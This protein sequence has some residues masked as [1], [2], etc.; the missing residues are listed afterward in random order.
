MQTTTRRAVL[1]GA[2]A[3]AAGLVLE[4]APAS[5]A[6]PVILPAADPIAHLLRRATFGPTPAALAEATRL[7]AAGW[8]DRQLNPATIADGDLD[9]L[10]TR[11][12]L[13]NA[14][15]PTV[16]AKLPKYS[17]DAFGDLGRAAVARAI[18]SN[19]QL[20]E[21]VA[22]FWAN[23]LHI[24]SPSSGVW[25][26]RPDYDRSVTRKHTFGRYADM[27]KASAR[28]PA[29]LNYLDNKSSTRSAPNE[30]YARELMEL[31]TV[32]LIYTEADVK[33][34]ARL[35]SGLTVTADGLYT[36]DASKHATGA[37]TILGFS[38]ANAT[39]EG[40]EAASLAFLDHLATHPATAQRLATKLCLRYVADEAP[41]SLVTKLAKVYLDNGT[42]ITPVL[43]AL[44]LSP[45]FA[46]S[47]GRKLRTPFEDLTATV[48]ALGLKP[49]AAGI[50]GLNALYN[51]AVNAG[52]AP[53]RWS[54]PNGFP[55]V[56]QAW[57]SPSAYLIRCNNHLN[58]AAGWYPKQLTRPADLLKYLVPV[59][60]ATYGGMVDAMSVSLAGTRL[61][62]EHTAAVLSVVGKL[63]TSP[64]TST[65]KYLEGQVP[66][67][68]AL[69][70]DSPTFQLR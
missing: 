47:T 46:A 36:Y 6:A 14:D 17:W 13:A 31:H 52:N 55:D 43:R 57:A 4:P 3:V 27:L 30:N 62:A 60:P 10:L 65:D 34:A 29:M 24:T 9:A 51:N 32:G 26:N 15:I 58:L 63:P 20:F 56:A 45:E 49:D 54:P 16:R 66:Y 33:A 67:L 48:R 25:D 12:P 18:W 11:L 61:P 70:L 39:A 22:A 21:S 68:A 7:G 1:G 2:T 41:P 19:R 23:H 28:H 69:V 8:L 53:F 40:G 64:V 5:A 50:E 42:A 35:L 59:L 44:F 37:V 38:H